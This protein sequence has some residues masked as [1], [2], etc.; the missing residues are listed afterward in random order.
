MRSH[1]L[2]VA[3][4]VVTARGPALLVAVLAIAGV[5]AGGAARWVFDP[6]TPPCGARAFLD[7]GVVRGDGVLVRGRHARLPA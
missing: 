1:R 3:G 4:P 6:P 2:S 5:V 7:Q